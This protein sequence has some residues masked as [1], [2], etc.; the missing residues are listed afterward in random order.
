MAFLGHG[1]GD[2]LHM[3]RLLKSKRKSNWNYVK[4]KTKWKWK[5]DLK[6]TFQIKSLMYLRPASAMA[7][8]NVSLWP[9]LAT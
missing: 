5:Y 1:I 7:L 3:A 9:V 4:I 8:V 6:N 2:C